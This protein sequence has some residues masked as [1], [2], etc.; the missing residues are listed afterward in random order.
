MDQWTK[1]EDSKVL[2]YLIQSMPNRIQQLL[3]NHI[4]LGYMKFIFSESKKI[5]N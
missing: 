2:E 3:C 1:L 4:C 5:D